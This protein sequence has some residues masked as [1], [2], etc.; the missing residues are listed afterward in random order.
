MAES[1][2]ASSEE[3]AWIRFI[4]AIMDELN[5]YIVWFRPDW[6]RRMREPACPRCPSKPPQPRPLGAA[7]P[8][9]LFAKMHTRIGPPPKRMTGR[10][11]LVDE[12]R[13]AAPPAPW[14]MGMGGRGRRGGV[15]DL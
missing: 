15:Q 6:E 14:G 7:P 3:Q 5:H 9:L 8:A 10:L 12:T 1:G 4:M 11:P 2:W 13:E